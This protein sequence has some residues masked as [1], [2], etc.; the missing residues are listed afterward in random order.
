MAKITVINHLT[1]D[2]VMQA[3]GRPDEDTRGGFAHGGWAAPNNDDVMMG[4]LGER[5]TG[6]PLLLGRRTYEQ[7]Y[8]YWPKQT[9]NPFSEALNHV[10]KHVASTSL[11]EP[12]PW[13]NSTLMSRD[14]PSA[15]ADLKA[16][17]DQDIVVMGSGELIRSLVPHDLIDEWL[18]MI[19]PLVLGEGGRLFTP[20][21]P[22]GALRL[23]DSVT[24]TK[25]VVIAT[26]GRAG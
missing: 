17:A 13:Q 23:L 4:K 22:V 25:G 8:D 11:S 24:S 12:L 19:H 10:Q 5:M 18:L 9:D 7:L 14:V 20:D 3:P 15:V 6:G 26:Y 2:G 1:L 21:R 16:S